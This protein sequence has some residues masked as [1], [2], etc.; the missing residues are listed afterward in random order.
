M[1]RI[2]VYVS[3]DVQGVFFRAYTRDEARKR[4]LEGWVC[5]TDDGR[6]EAVIEG[7]ESA[8][9]E[10]VIWLHKGTPYSNITNV[11]I[12]REEPS[13]IFNSFDIR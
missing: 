4:G 11:E 7:E 12:I 9:K 3:G 10:M 8:L 2:H 6:V 5:N 13:K 1:K